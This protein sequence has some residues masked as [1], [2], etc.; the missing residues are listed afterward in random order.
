MKGF[1]F[2]ESVGTRGFEPPTP[3]PPVKYANQTAPRPVFHFVTTPKYHHD[4]S[5][6]LRWA[7]GLETIIFKGCTKIEDIDL[8]VNIPPGLTQP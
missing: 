4:L 2:I 6:S 5:S 1:K 8:E 3:W 7:S